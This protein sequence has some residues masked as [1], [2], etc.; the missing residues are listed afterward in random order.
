M[1]HVRF[2][3]RREQQ[4]L[5]ALSAVAGRYGTGKDRHAPRAEAIAAVHEV[6]TNPWLLHVQPNR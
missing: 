4:V 5:A 3:L 2:L 1:V 6:T